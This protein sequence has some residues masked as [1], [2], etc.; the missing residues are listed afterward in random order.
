[1][2]LEQQLIQDEGIRLKPY[3][4]SLGFLTI[5]VGRN[6]ESNFLTPSE[7]AYIYGKPVCK[8]LVKIKLRK[9]ISEDAALYLLRN[10]I[11]KVKNQLMG[12]HWHNNIPGAKQEVLQ[13]MCFNMG[14]PRLLKFKKMIA[15]L[16]KQD[17]KTAAEEMLNSKWA[18]QV[19]Q[20]AI[21]LAQIMAED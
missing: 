18:T 5:G 16:E 3:K 20:R 19:G 14:L 4:D 7:I 12:F 6:L 10:D 1:M 9:G 13:N 17:Y 2:S 11:E 15:A 21:R 8:L